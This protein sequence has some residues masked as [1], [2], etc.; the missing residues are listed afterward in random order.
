[1][2]IVMYPQV[3]ILAAA[4]AAAAAALIKECLSPHKHSHAA[5]WQITP[6]LILTFFFFIEAL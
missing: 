1:M 6:S 4:A 5:V 2:L 3:L